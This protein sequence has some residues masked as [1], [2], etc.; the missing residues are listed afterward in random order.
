VQT[1]FSLILNECGFK[2]VEPTVDHKILLDGVAFSEF[3]LRRG[4]LVSV[5]ARAEIKAVEK[6]TG[7]AAAVLA[8]RVIPRLVK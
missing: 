2:V 7:K 5:K 6:A 4:N 3:S 8:E 1:E